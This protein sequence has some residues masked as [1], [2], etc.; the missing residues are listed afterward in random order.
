MPRGA[1]NTI[2]VGEVNAGFKP[3]G[4]PINWR[5]PAAG[6]NGDANTFGGP[7]KNNGTTFLMADG[8]VRFIGNGVDPEVLRA[9][10]DPRAEK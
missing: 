8:S 4:H 9:M 2:L 6:L 1:S 10:S 7:A 3:W 5:D